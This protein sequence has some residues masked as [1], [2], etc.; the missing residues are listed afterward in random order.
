MM[1]R[2]QAAQ[3]HYQKENDAIMDSMSANK[4]KQRL[5][6]QQIH[7]NK[8]AVQ[9]LR[10]NCSIQQKNILTHTP[11]GKERRKVIINDAIE[12]IGNAESID[13]TRSLGAGMV[14]G[15]MQATEETGDAAGFSRAPVEMSQLAKPLWSFDPARA[16]LSEIQK[17][18]ALPSTLSKYVP[19]GTR[20]RMNDLCSVLITHGN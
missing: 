13:A 5:I 14:V 18:L 2:L 8:Q 3:I 20:L 6:E 19:V 7:E 11:K 1:R 10:L 4:D 9:R 17:G 15:A 12:R 16:T